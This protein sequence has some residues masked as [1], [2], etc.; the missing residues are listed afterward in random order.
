MNNEEI[1]ELG[2]KLGIP[3]DESTNYKDMLE[4][5]IVVFNGVNN[6]RFLIEGTW[7]DH[8]IYRKMGEALKQMGRKSLKMDLNNLLSIMS[9]H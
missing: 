7:S 1:I 2:T 5:N 3:F 6:Q 9:D 8:E 4:R